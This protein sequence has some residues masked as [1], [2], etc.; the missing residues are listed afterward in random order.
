MPAKAGIQVRFTVKV[1]KP[2]GFR[3]APERRNKGRLPVD[4]FET[5]W[6]RGS[7]S[8]ASLHGIGV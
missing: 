8:L 3:L 2:P 7:S 4:E 5:P 6:S 1:Q